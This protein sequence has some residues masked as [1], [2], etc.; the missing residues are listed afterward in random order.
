MVSRSRWCLPLLLIALALPATAAAQDDSWLEE[1]VDPNADGDGDDVVEEE[2]LDLYQGVLVVPLMGEDSRSVG[3]G[4]LLETFLLDALS[5]NPTYDVLALPEVEQ[6]QGMAAD[7]YYEGCPRGDELGCQFVIGEVARVD[8][9]VSGRVSVESGDSYRVVVTILGVKSADLEF[10]YAL[11]LR[12]GE[13]DLLPRTVA[14]ALDRL[15]REELEAPDRDGRERR[16][17]AQRDMERARTDEEQR[18]VARMEMDLDEDLMS[19]LQSELTSRRPTR[20]LTREDLSDQRENRHFRSEWETLGITEKQYL[21]YKN[22]GLDYD[23]WRWRWAGHRFQILGSVYGGGAFGALA[24]RYFSRYLQSPDLQY[25]VDSY[26]W[27]S[28]DKLNTGALGFGIGFG[29][30]RNLDVEFSLWWM[31]SRVFL[32]L[33]NGATVACTS[34]ED[35]CFEPDPN[36]RPLPPT[37]ADQRINLLAADVMARFYF[38]TVPIVR[39]SVGAGLAWLSYPSLASA[40]QGQHTVFERFTDVGPQVEGGVMVEFGRWGGLFVRV[41]FVFLLNPARQQQ[42][43]SQPTIMTVYDEPVDSPPGILRV[44]VGVQGRIL[45]MPVPE[46]DSRVIDL[47]FDEEFE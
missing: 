11:D 29:I 9:V 33:S 15:R 18:V 21:S 17:Q 42:S 6:V 2:P 34:G 12:A 45:G 38:L 7:L 36:N 20:Q 1:G 5:R 26:A 23:K 13:E 4:A 31:Q 41:P 16:E 46:R 27:Q 39:P 44:L 37:Y 30:L 28:V 8:R 35:Q 24:L 14:L 10:S 22:S 3:I 47:D 19:E 40:V 43:D 32:K 25:L